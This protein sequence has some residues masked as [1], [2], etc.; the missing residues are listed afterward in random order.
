MADLA[1]NLG[2]MIFGAVFAFAAI[3]AGALLLI[4]GAVHWA[5]KLFSERKGKKNETHSTYRRRHA[6]RQRRRSG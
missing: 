2:L 4:W 3:G 5:R 1:S 6:G